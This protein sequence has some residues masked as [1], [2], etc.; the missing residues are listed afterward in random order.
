[1][2]LHLLHPQHKIHNHGRQQRQRQHR[3]SKPIVNPRLA[4][5]ANTLRPPV[6]RHQR[7]DHRPHGDDGE[8]AGG[9][10]PDAVSEVQQADGQTAQD[11]REVE[12]GEECALVGEEDFGLD[13][14]GERDA[15]AFC[16]GG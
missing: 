15:F 16:L 11:D 6:K 14:C 4:A 3:R 7:V 5:F 8:Q 1:M 13:S 9:D 12:P 10:A 2:K